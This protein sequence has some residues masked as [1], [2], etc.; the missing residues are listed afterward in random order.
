MGMRLRLKAWSL[1]QDMGKLK[2]A[3]AF[4]CLCFVFLTGCGEAKVPDV[5]DAPT[6]SIG[7]KGQIT[8][9]Q[10]GEFDRADYILSELKDMAVEEATQF[11]IA[12]QKNAAVAVESVEALQ[13]GS[14]RVMVVYKFDGWESCGEFL[15]EDLFF[16]TVKEAAL[17]GFNTNVSMK[18]AKD[19][20]VFTGEQLKQSG[21]KYLVI[22]DMKANIYCSGRVAYISGDAALNEDGSVDT[23][24]VEGLAYILLK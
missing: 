9:W 19:G 10:V 17:K 11:N 14:G 13:D 16:G 22:T 8:V 21:D 20:A 15:E 3:A 7:K 24:G 18:G 12:M 4:L 5:I 2:S 1:V 23:S 6:V